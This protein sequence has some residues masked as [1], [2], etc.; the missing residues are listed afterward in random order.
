MQRMDELNLGFVFDSG[1]DD[2]SQTTRNV[3]QR[4]AAASPFL[5]S[6]LPALVPLRYPRLGG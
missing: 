6:V 3:W 5:K 4:R 2:W 1:P